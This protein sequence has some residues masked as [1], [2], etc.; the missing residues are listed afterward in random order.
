[1]TATIQRLIVSSSR[2]PDALA[3]YRDA[4]GLRLDRE[5]EGLAWLTSADG[6]E[7]MLH[8]RE[9]QP[10]DTAV[11]I[12]FAVDRL[13]AVVDAWAR[14]GGSVVDAPQAQPWGE[15]MAVVRDGDGHIV[16]LSERA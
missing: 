2:I 3:L 10:S 5:A 12:G 8:E 4:L 6:V 11:A 15:R 14:A 9:A 7:L 13:D 16:C 1:M